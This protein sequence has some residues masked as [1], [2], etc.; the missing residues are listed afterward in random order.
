[1]PS[2]GA[3][4]QLPP[5]DAFRED[6]SKDLDGL[7]D[8]ALHQFRHRAVPHLAAAASDEQ[9]LTD[10]RRYDVPV[11]VISCTFTREEIETYTA[12]GE[13]YFAELPRLR[14]LTVVELPTGHWPQFS[15]P[16][17]LGHIIAEAIG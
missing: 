3:D 16:D 5:W 13:T 2:A 14:D 8:A 6:G 9:Q 1:M 10:E 7:D 12:A 15:R 17:D 4:L 11:T